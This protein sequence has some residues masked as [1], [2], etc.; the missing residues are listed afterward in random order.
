MI[1]SKV[2]L[3]LRLTTDA[4]DT[5]LLDLVSAAI[6]DLHHVGPVFDYAVAYGQN[7]GITDYDVMDPLA[8]MAIITYCRMH[9]GSP[10][11]FD[12]LAG[13]YA[14]QK[15]QMRES[16]AFGMKGRC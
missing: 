4:Y 14:E 6:A 7:G 16:R 13:S 1:L 15:G 8:T 5:E 9:F 12:K 11:D 2:K 10:A 3:A